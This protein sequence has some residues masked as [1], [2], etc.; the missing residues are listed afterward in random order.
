MTTPP[1][2]GFPNP[3]H[4][5]VDPAHEQDIF[6]AIGWAKWQLEQARQKDKLLRQGNQEISRRFAIDSDE[7]TRVPEPL[8][9]VQV[10][11][12]PKTREPS[13]L[14][15]ESVIIYVPVAETAAAPDF[16]RADTEAKKVAT[17][18]V[19][20]K[21]IRGGE[22]IDVLLNPAGLQAVASIKDVIP[23]PQEQF[24]ANGQA[25]ARAR[26]NSG[27]VAQSELDS[28][29][30]GLEEATMMLRD[31]EPSLQENYGPSASQVA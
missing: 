16:M 7:R 19:F 20:I 5:N 28:H 18:D 4:A 3:H 2:E 1:N 21:A 25:Y 10:T 6:L 30:F 11:L 27:D 26:T 9:H 29:W 8:N 22:S 12:V 13:V 23:A 14:G 24:D 17:N 15:I 31:Y